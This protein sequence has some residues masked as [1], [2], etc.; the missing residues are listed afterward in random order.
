MYLAWNIVSKPSVQYIL[1]E[2]RHGIVIEVWT[3]KY[4]LKYVN[5]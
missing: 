4:L 2:V 5:G 1:F 3:L